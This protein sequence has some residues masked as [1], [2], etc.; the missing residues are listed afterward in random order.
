MCCCAGAGA[1]R[2]FYLLFLICAVFKVIPCDRINNINYNYKGFYYGVL[3]VHLMVDFLD[4]KMALFSL[5]FIFHYNIMFASPT[6][7]LNLMGKWTLLKGQMMSSFWLPREN[8][9]CNV[10]NEDRRRTES[11]KVECKPQL[12]DFIRNQAFELLACHQGEDSSGYSFLVRLRVLTNI[13]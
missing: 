5:A 9:D 8:Y 7:T 12:E 13:V 1:G 11:M 3:R 2:L 6:V 4:S 10:K